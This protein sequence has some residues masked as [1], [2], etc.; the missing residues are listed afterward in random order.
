MTPAA[1]RCGH[2]TEMPGA[3]PGMRALSM[4]H[5]FRRGPRPMAS[6]DQGVLAEQVVQSVDVGEH[7][8]LA[9]GPDPTGITP[10][11][12]MLVDALACQVGHAAEFALRQ[13]EVNVQT[14]ILEM[15]ME[16]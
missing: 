14:A 3:R 8:R 15:R 7:D 9:G 12:Q 13:L 2:A 6:D 4:F 10:S 5:G 11:R 1:Q 16:S